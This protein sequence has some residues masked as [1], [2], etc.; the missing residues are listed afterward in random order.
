MRTLGLIRRRAY[1]LIEMLVVIAILAVLM[2]LLFVA[3]HHARESA[4]LLQN[5]NNLRQMILGVHQ[6]GDQNGGEIRDLM[7][8]STTGLQA[9]SS[10]ASLF[11]RLTPYVDA[12]VRTATTCLPRKCSSWPN[13]VI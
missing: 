9:I 3:V 7:R 2:G 12:P 8:S 10:D 5:K 6:L 11:Y 4:A 1:T 13:R